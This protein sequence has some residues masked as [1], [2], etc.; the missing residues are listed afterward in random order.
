MDL[1]IKH[2][3]NLVPIVAVDYSLA[4]LT[5][6]ESCYCLHTLKA[7][8]TNDYV[9]VLRLIENCFHKFSKF[10]LGYGFGAR[11]K[12]GD[13]PSCDL[14]SMTG[15]MNNPYI[16]M[17]ENQLICNYAKT[18]RSVKLALPVNFRAIIKL[19]CDLAQIEF[20]TISD[21]RQIKNFYVL[22]ILM[23]GVI[24]DFQDAL[25]ELM[26]AANLPVSVV[27]IKIGGMQEENDSA[28]L[29][30]QSQEAFAKCDRQFVRVLD[31]DSQYKKKASGLFEGD[32]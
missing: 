29:M 3:L 28:N 17:K 11:T 31:F 5:F 15:D 32:P 19:V 10:S 1:H 2:G 22:V 7:E 8:A 30:S 20:G 13:G 27:V 21:I 4:N 24:D 25:N 9:E 6:D 23:A 14:I 26:R 16:D 18:L 12:P